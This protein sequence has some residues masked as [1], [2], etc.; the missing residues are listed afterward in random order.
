MSLPLGELEAPGG[1]PHGRCQGNPQD[2]VF[3]QK[4]PEETREASVRDR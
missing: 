1:H 4:L 2:G 3:Q